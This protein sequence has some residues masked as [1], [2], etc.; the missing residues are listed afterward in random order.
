MN[1]FFILF[2]SL[3]LSFCFFLS[4]YHTSEKSS[5][6]L[7]VTV[8]LGYLFRPSTL[9]LSQV[10]WPVLADEFHVYEC[11]GGCR[12]TW[13]IARK[14][15]RLGMMSHSKCCEG[16]NVKIEYTQWS[17]ISLW[18]LN[19]RLRPTFGLSPDAIPFLKIVSTVKQIILIGQCLLI[20]GIFTSII[21]CSP[22]R[23]SY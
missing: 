20:I 17:T 5:F 2:F 7:S 14:T 3:F 11:I 10:L 1:F 13:N 15:W 21:Q 23:I 16:R 18:D 4:R 12:E 19:V 6:P 8:L 22:T 9:L